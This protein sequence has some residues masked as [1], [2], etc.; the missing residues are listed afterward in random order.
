[1]EIS[2]REWTERLELEIRIDTDSA[3]IYAEQLVE[4]S[5][6]GTNNDILHRGFLIELSVKIL[7]VQS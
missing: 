1:M 6:T 2:T 4:N 5:I 7:A 3:K